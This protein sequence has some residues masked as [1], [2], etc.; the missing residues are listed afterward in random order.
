MEGIWIWFVGW[1]LVSGGASNCQSSADIFAQ[2]FHRLYDA[3]VIRD[4]F[5]RLVSSLWPYLLDDIGKQAIIRDEP[6]PVFSC[7]NGIAIFRADPLLPPHLRT[8]NLLSKT[9]LSSPLL[10][11]H[12]AYNVSAEPV[13]PAD[14]P[15]LSFRMSSRG[16]CFSSE[17]F[18]LSY[19]FRRQFGLEKI[20]VNPR[21]IVAY[22]WSLYIWYKY[23]LRHWAVKWW[24]E[25][26]ERGRG[27]ESAK[28]IVGSPSAVYTWD[29]GECH[30]GL[31]W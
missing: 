12:P 17:C 24:I 31:D 7:W 27:M 13:A 9:P 22:D 10:A 19:D 15:A 21:V 3:W 30:P 20:Y 1:T 2:D 5:G 28:M 4:R 8:S 25:N 14:A 16:E 29:G 18:L 6:A 26:V 11:T 23:V